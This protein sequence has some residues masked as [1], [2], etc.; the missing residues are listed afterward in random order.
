MPLDVLVFISPKPGKERRVEEILNTVTEKIRSDEP[1][2][3]SYHW[4][5]YKNEEENSVDYVV[6][7]RPVD[8]SSLLCSEL[9]SRSRLKN[10]ESLEK[11]RDLQ[12][13]RDVAQYVKAEDLL[14][15]PLRY[16]KLEPKG[17]FDR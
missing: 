1:Y 16:V 13:H 11:R 2:T 6:S 5:E 4:Y 17:G 14:R 15:K 8:T 3:L 7:A 10:E 12:H 9:T